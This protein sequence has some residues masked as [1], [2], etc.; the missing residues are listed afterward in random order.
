M[1]F[2]KTRPPPRHQVLFSKC[3]SISALIIFGAKVCHTA[4]IMTWTL[5]KEEFGYCTRTAKRFILR[6]WMGLDCAHAHDSMIEVY[7]LHTVAFRSEL[8]PWLWLHKNYVLD[9]IN[10]SLMPAPY[11]AWF[12]FQSWYVV[13][14]F[15]FRF[16]L[17]WAYITKFLFFPLIP[18]KCRHPS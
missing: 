6:F 18:L 14:Q 5:F 10:N 7:W 4:V 3:L 12:L 1:A 13:K 9:S 15:N 2:H 11:K 17:G 16:S 8:L